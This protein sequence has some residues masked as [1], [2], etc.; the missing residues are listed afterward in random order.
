MAHRIYYVTNLKTIYAPPFP[1]NISNCREFNLMVIDD[2]IKL[3]FYHDTQVQQIVV[4]DQTINDGKTHRHSCGKTGH[5]RIM[6]GYVDKSIFALNDPI[7]LEEFSKTDIYKNKTELHVEF[8]AHCNINLCIT[9]LEHGLKLKQIKNPTQQLVDTAIRLDS[10]NLKYVDKKFINDEMRQY[11]KSIP[12]KNRILKEIIKRNP[13]LK[14]VP[15]FPQT[16]QIQTELTA[17]QIIDQIRAA[18]YEHKELL[19]KEHNKFD[20]M[21]SGKKKILDWLYSFDTLPIHC[22]YNLASIGYAD[23]S[24]KRNAL[25]ETNLSENSKSRLNITKA[26]NLPAYEVKVKQ[27]YEKVYLA[28]LNRLFVEQESVFKFIYELGYQIIVYTHSYWRRGTDVY[29]K[30]FETWEKFSTKFKAR[31]NADYTAIILI[32]PVF[33]GLNKIPEN[34]YDESSEDEDEDESSESE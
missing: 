19:L 33:Y 22:T 31:T 4:L 3:K 7:S 12:N 20:Q 34:E 14:M 1:F 24:H 9:A 10:K 5:T 11:I 29:L 2:L 6:L 15:V 25:W 23:E 30:R 21:G 26:I 17:R 13:C 18:N 32:D 8:D 28:D 16:S 27:N